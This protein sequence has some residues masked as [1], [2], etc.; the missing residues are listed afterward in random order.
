MWKQEYDESPLTPPK[1]VKG[2]MIFLFSVVGFFVL[3][4]FLMGISTGLYWLSFAA[5]GFVVF[6]V[7]LFYP[8]W[9]PK[10][11][12]KKLSRTGIIIE[13]D[14]LDIIKG[15]YSN[16]SY[17]PCRFRAQWLDSEMNTVY[18]FISPNLNVKN[19]DY[20]KTYPEKISADLAAS[21]IKVV[22]NPEN[23]KEYYMEKEEILKF[24]H[25][26]I[27]PNVA[28]ITQDMKQKERQE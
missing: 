20:F 2:S 28:E 16:G 10:V 12:Q 25:T 27:L 11:M 13:A 7:G 15:S 4:F 22:I 23:P 3:S 5:I 19:L 17:N 9:K 8:S 24:V 21:S 18:H 1:G 14:F 6:I 26:L